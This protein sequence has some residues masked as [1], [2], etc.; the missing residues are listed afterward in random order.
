VCAMT[1][2]CE[3]DPILTSWNGGEEKG[4]MQSGGEG[5]TKEAVQNGGKGEKTRLR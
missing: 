1:G 2:G 3:K 4:S 5:C